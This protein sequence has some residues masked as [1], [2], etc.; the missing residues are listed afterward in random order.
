MTVE[1]TED[2]RLKLYNKGLSDR[3]IA[4]KLYLDVSTIT[5][6]RRHKEL[7][8]NPPPNNAKRKPKFDTIKAKAL[9]DAGANDVLI[10]TKLGVNKVTIRSWRNDNN[11]PA[12]RKQLNNIPHEEIIKLYNSGMSDGAISRQ[13]GL[14]SNTIGAWRKRNNLEPNFPYVSNTIDYNK[15][16]E[17]YEAGELDTQIAKKLDISYDMVV[18]WRKGL[19][20]QSNREKR[21]LTKHGINS[22]EVNVFEHDI[23]EDTESLLNDASFLDGFL[24]RDNLNQLKNRR[25]EKKS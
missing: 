7:P 25:K 14:S 3:E 12:I 1:D 8:P 17:L 18:K 5:A 10:A 23:K 9:Y 2:N 11:L 4:E 16:K 19:D 21:Y 15:V 20:L 22:N 6:W 13:L 24:R